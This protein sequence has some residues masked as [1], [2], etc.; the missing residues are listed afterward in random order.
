MEEDHIFRWVRNFAPAM[1]KEFESDWKFCVNEG[2]VFRQKKSNQMHVS[3]NPKKLPEILEAMN[4][5][6]WKK[7]ELSMAHLTT[8]M[9]GVP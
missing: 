9:V 7:C 1:V 2:W 5:T 3:L 6:Q 8:N 4:Q